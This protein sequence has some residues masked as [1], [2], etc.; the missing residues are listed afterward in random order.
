MIRDVE[1]YRENVGMLLMY[2]YM[3]IAMYVELMWASQCTS[4][5]NVSPKNWTST[6]PCTWVVLL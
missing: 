5:T 3:C 6:N 2:V 4:Q 1:S